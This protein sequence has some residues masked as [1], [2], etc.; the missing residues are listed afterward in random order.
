MTNEGNI[1]RGARGSA[2]PAVNGFQR[3]DIEITFTPENM[4]IK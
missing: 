4:R 2:T 1:R 3:W